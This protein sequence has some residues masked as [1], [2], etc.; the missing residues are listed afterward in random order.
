MIEKP[1][2]TYSDEVKAALKNGNPVVALESTIISQGMPY[3]ENIETSRSVEAIIRNNLVVPATIG[4][5]A[6][7]IK[8]GLSADELEQ[9]ATRDDV[10]KV[11]RRDLA[12]SLS[13]KWYG[14]TTVAAT[15]I[16]AQFAGIRVF[17][18]GG[19]GGVHRLGES[20]LD[21]SAD[22]VELSQTKVAVVC[23]GVKAILDIPRT[24]EF[25]E[26]HGVPVI[27]YQ[28]NEFPA[29]FT[30]TSGCKAQA[31]LHSA[32]AVADFI[33]MQ[34]ALGLKSGVVIAN[35]VPTESAMDE[36]TIQKAIGEVLQ[37]AAEQKIKGKTATPYLLK[38]VN[39]LTGGCSLQSNIALIRNNACL[40]AQIAVA[41]H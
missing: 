24:L 37:E 30:R 19:I 5:M 38:R 13:E 33:K 20:T 40:G 1:W 18:T 25:L 7:K 39:D 17:V 34:W 27:G 9:F 4:I 31:T 29:F 11:S 28:T 41:Y 8:I 23:A 10:V 16:C 36:L 2:I 14:G 3:P 12:L 22:L 15:M 26:T 6:G 21:I 35:P 32:K